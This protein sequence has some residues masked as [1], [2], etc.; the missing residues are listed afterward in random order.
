MSIHDILPELT[1]PVF[2]ECQQRCTNFKWRILYFLLGI[3]EPP[4]GVSIT[5]SHWIFSISNCPLK[6]KN[7]QD[8]LPQQIHKTVLEW[9]D[10]QQRQ[11]RMN[12]IFD[13]AMC[14]TCS[15]FQWNEYTVDE[16][17]ELVP[18]LFKVRIDFDVTCEDIHR[19]HGMLQGSD[20]LPV[21]ISPHL[22][23]VHLAETVD[24]RMKSHTLTEQRTVY[25][26]L[27]EL[28]I[29]DEIKVQFVQGSVP[30]NSMLPGERIAISIAKKALSK[31]GAIPSVIRF[32]DL[33]AISERPSCLLIY[34]DARGRFSET[35][36]K[37][38]STSAPISRQFCARK[39]PTIAVYLGRCIDPLLIDC[40]VGRRS[41]DADDWSRG[42]VFRVCNFNIL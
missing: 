12:L 35:V 19:V 8:V 26:L 24:H 18:F 10:L 31:T 15:K 40:T 25:N 1:F 3:N 39:L 34:M 36:S 32:E 7:N 11:G 2:F 21:S 4:V 6:G 33:S 30:V 28:L 42:S 9:N 16:L 27:I 38:C 17:L 23:H 37:R 20:T 22:R 5:S 14:Y 41:D 29:A 13:A